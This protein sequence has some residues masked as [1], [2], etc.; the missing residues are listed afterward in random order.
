MNLY[1]Y[2]SRDLLTQ[3]LADGLVRQQTHETL[4][5][6]ILNYTHKAMYEWQWTETVRRCR[7]LIYDHDTNEIVARSYEKFFNIEEPEAIIPSLSPYGFEIYD[8]SD[9]QLIIATRYQGQLVVSSRGSFTSEYAAKA[10][11]ILV[12]RDH[13]NILE[14][15]TWIFEL[16]GYERIV[17]DYPEP[18]LVLHGLRS[19]PDGFAAPKPLLDLF[20]HGVGCKAVECHYEAS[21]PRDPSFS[22]T[23]LSRVLTDLGNRL[24]YEGR[25]GFVI[26]FFD[27]KET[28]IKVKTA[29]YKE[30]H[31]ALSGLS[32]VMIWKWMCEGKDLKSL[33]AILPDEVHEWTHRWHHWLRGEAF[34]KQGEALQILMAL[35]D[36]AENHAG[37]T[38]PAA[39][40]KHIALGW[41]DQFPWIN[42]GLLWGIYQD[43]DT[44][45]QALKLVKPELEKPAFTDSITNTAA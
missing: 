24:G 20:A 13:G 28:R 16:V 39:I 19:T 40:R 21:F 38:D 33:L 6:T 7:G 26:R 11:D 31:A 2:V 45:L 42:G 10:Y 43:Q 8:K 36:S 37:L 34:E 30:R 5:L 27:D 35:K 4:P 23:S 41:K 44:W 18:A 22:I 14:G 29:W 3:A 15:E 1:D 12:E 25:E 17:L 9:G 32:S